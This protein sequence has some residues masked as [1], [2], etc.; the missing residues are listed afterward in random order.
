MGEPVGEGRAVVEDVLVGAPGPGLDRRREGAVLGPELEDLLLEAGVVG[1]LVDLRD[2]APGRQAR[3]AS[4][5]AYWSAVRAAPDG[6][7]PGP[8]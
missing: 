7:R 2:T 4:P 1:L 5:T 3:R 8:E 6:R